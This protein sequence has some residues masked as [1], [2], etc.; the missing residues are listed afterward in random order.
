MTTCREIF[1]FSW[2]LRG[3]GGGGNPSGQPDRFFPV[4]F[5]DSPKRRR[6]KLQAFWPLHIFFHWNVVL[7]YFWSLELC[8]C[9]EL[10]PWGEFVYLVGSQ[11]YSLLFQLQ[12]RQRP[13]SAASVIFLVLHNHF[14]TMVHQLWW[15]MVWFNSSFIGDWHW[16][17]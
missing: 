16:N 10:R 11:L 9:S 5:Y 8:C 12:S 14:K 17:K 2:P 1:T 4:F 13:P 7:K 15:S 6:K 3:R